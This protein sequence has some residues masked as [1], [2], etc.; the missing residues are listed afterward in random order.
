MIGSR[1]SSLRFPI[2]N[3]DRDHLYEEFAPLIRSLTRRFA[4]DTDLRE[5][6]TGEIY[7]RFFALLEAYDPTRGIPIRPY[8]VRQLTASVYTYARH[9]WRLKKRE[10]ELD[11]L[12]FERASASD[13][14]PEWDDAIIIDQVSHKLPSAIGKLPGRQS[15]V[16]VWRYYHDRSY[17]E[18]ADEMG[19]ESSTARSLARH[20]INH[21]RGYLRDSIANEPE[22]AFGHHGRRHNS[23]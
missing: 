10:I 6:L 13:P 15:Q 12:V 8:L 2:D 19:I 5:E 3:A 1:E 4:T 18:I 16:L 21:L 22:D 14:T 9:H 17:D 20:A 11:A 7:F 23:P